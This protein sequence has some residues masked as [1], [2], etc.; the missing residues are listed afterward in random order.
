MCK[1][2]LVHDD[3]GLRDRLVRRLRASVADDYEVSVA[4]DMVTAVAELGCQT[5]DVIIVD[6]SLEA[7]PGRDRNG[8][9]VLELAKRRCP[10]TP[11][12]VMTAFGGIRTGVEA[13][14]LGAFDYIEEN[15]PG[16]SALDLLLSKLPLA[17]A[18][19]QASMRP[20]TVETRN[21]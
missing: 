11:V 19:S 3:G 5:F 13:L 1:L 17:V 10:A 18:H 2:L 6:V 8:L 15:W 7:P 14:Q 20:P 21:G 12:I 16:V 9:R 4:P